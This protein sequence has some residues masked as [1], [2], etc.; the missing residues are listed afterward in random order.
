M[1]VTILEPIFTIP[2]YYYEIGKLSVTLELFRYV[3]MHACVVYLSREIDKITRNA[4]LPRIHMSKIW[5]YLSQMFMTILTERTYTT[6]LEVNLDDGL[7]NRNKYDAIKD[8]YRDLNYATKSKYF[9]SD[10]FEIGKWI[11]DCIG[12]LK[13]LQSAVD[14]KI[15]PFTMIEG[16]DAV[17]FKINMDLLKRSVTGNVSR[18]IKQQL[19]ENRNL[20]MMFHINKDVYDRVQKRYIK[21][22]YGFHNLLLCCLIRYDVLG[23]GANQYMVDLNYKDELAKFGVDF[24]C[25]ASVFN[26]YYPNYCSMFYDLERHFGSCGSFMALQI[27]QGMYMANPP[28]S[29]YLL[30]RM[31][32]KVKL[33]L[34]SFTPVF[35]IMSI[36]KWN[37]FPLQTQIE[38]YHLYSVGTIKREKFHI[39][40]EHGK[41]VPIPEYIS[42]LFFNEAFGNS[43]ENTYI[44]DLEKL[45]RTFKNM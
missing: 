27:K 26:C 32:D 7:F 11:D 6:E 12:M 39:P 33:A 36:P 13:S 30:Y 3:E 17:T 23:S 1:S 2:N 19:F 28:Y 44:D 8:F 38:T 35:F 45:F 14:Q 34:Q 24:E 25:F 21:N 29:E 22:E 20:P 42:Y 10:M 9:R 43:I 37:A 41:L 5:V 16:D 15:E 18:Y 4:Q 40:M 31:Y